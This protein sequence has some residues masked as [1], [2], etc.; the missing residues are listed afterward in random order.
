MQVMLD[1]EQ[2]TLVVTRV[3]HPSLASNA[4]AYLL[5]TQPPVLF[6][7]QTLSASCIIVRSTIVCCPALSSIVAPMH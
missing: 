7:S 3:T 6:G 4:G 1:T 2:Q 5:T